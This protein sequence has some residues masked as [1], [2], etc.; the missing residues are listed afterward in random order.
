MKVKPSLKEHVEA[1]QSLIELASEAQVIC[2]LILESGG[3]LSPEL[4]Q[5]LDVNTT[6]LL[7]KV[8]SYVFIEEHLEANA[9]LWKRKADACKSIHDRYVKAQDR[10]R[11]RI[12]IG[13]QVLERDELKGK[14]YRYKLSKLK[15]KLVIS[16]PVKL[17]IE[18]KMVVS[19]TVPDKE[20]IKSLLEDGIEVP[21]ASLEPVYQLRD[22]ENSGE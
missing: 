5:K 2:K 7:A 20:K 11:D 22:Y 19:E 16:D 6:A 14:N 13:M 1:T 18:C 3:E 12:K 8:D 21:G 15:P 10:L 4:E 9:A 17:P